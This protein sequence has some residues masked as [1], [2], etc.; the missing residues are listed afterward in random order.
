MATRLEA[1]RPLEAINYAVDWSDY[2]GEDTIAGSVVEGVGVTAIGS[3]V[4][5]IVTLTISGGT[6]GTLGKVTN[7]ITSA[8]GLVEEEVFFVYVSNFEEPVSV[9]ELKDHLGLWADNT[10]DARIASLGRAAR[11]FC[12]EF[13]GHVLVRRQ[14]TLERPTFEEIVLTK[15]PLVDVDTLEYDDVDGNEATFEDYRVNA[16]I[17]P[18]RILAASG[19]SFPSVWSD[20]GVSAIYTAGYDEGEVPEPFIHAIKVLVAFWFDHPSGIVDGKAVE[21]PPAA[22]SLLRRY[23]QPAFA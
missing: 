18:A 9:A 2:L 7:R 16:R 14:F 4:G 1:K 21:V 20:G 19:Y 13:T 23:H 11:E 5:N 6:S 22:K 12:E 15:R 10:R 3:P 8:G 17:Y